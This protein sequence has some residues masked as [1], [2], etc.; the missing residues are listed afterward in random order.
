MCGS[1][2]SGI[3]AFADSAKVTNTPKS[4]IEGKLGVHPRGGDFKGD[5]EKVGM[6]KHDFLA[7][8]LTTQVTVGVLTKDQADKIQ[9]AAPQNMRMEKNSDDIKS[10]NL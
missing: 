1:F 5:I 3:V 10:R 6:E 4:K 2:R 7:N 8:V 9:A